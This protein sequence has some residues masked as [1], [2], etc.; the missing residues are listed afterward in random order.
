MRRREFITLIGGGA[1]AAWPLAARAQKPIPVIGF[2]G[3]R[4]PATE[5]EFAAAIR[6]GLAEHGYVEG[7]NVIIEYRVVGNQYDRIPLPRL[8]RQNRNVIA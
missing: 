6:A 8:G 1:A 5:P 2:L 7:Q 4:T 3:V